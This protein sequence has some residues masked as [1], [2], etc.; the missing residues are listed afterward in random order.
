MPPPMV[1]FLVH[2]AHSPE[3][4]GE[5]AR[6][7]RWHD[8]TPTAIWI[9]AEP[10]ARMTAATLVQILEWSGPIEERDGLG[11]EHTD[12]GLIASALGDAPADA[13]VVIVAHEPLLSALAAR[14]ATGADRLLARG[15]ALRLDDGEVRWWFAHDDVAP[16]RG[17]RP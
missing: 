10:A 9:S 11:A 3:D 14:L 2:H 5:L 4:A 16:V 8:C 12:P 7:L 13:A 1:V 17:A 6:R 15:E